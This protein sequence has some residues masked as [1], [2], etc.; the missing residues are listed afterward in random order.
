MT[1]AYARMMTMNEIADDFNENFIEPL[2][3]D[4]S[5]LN[6]TLN[7]TDKTFTVNYGTEELMKFNYTDE[8]MEY[9]V[10]GIEI[11][12]EVAE[13]GMYMWLKK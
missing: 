6:A 11:T 3:K 9:D 5:S 13:D 1:V 12:E 8:Y 2:R 7:E 10:R 4:G